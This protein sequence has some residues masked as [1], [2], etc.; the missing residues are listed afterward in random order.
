MAC[1]ICCLFVH[2]HDRADLGLGPCA[3]LLVPVRFL[4]LV[5]DGVV[6]GVHEGNH[7]NCLQPQGEE[8]DQEMRDAMCPPPYETRHHKGYEQGCDPPCH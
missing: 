5:E 1:L 2:D 7:K 8:D 4:V 3:A 6:D